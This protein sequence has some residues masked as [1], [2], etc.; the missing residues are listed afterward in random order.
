[1]LNEFTIEILQATGQ[2][3]YMVVWSVFGA[4][5]LGW[6]LGTWLY[7]SEKIH[8]N[9][10]ICKILNGLINTTRSIPFIIFMVALL[11][12]TRWLLGSAIGL[13]AAIVPLTLGATPLFA[14]LTTQAYE[15]LPEGIVECAHSIGATPK[16][17]IQR[18]FFK[19]TLPLLI[20]ATTMTAI[21]LVGYSA[22]AGVIGGGG[23]GDLA[24]RYG[25]QRFN[26]TIMLITIVILIA[27]V[28]CIQWL[29]QTIRKKIQH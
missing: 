21:T 6:P 28:Q 16:Q 20:D 29:G 5:L 8:P 18:M 22:M 23:L 14:R 24:I 7:I 19:E 11:P 9:R 10:L 12:L 27:M 26:T 15:Q 25:Y 17:M 4:I 2:T 3:I 1:M 13:H